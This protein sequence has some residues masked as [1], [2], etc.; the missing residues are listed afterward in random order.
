ML[1]DIFAV[2][3]PYLHIGPDPVTNLVVS[4]I[5]EREVSFSWFTGSAGSFPISAIEM[6]VFPPTGVPFRL[7]L[8]NINATT[9]TDLMPFSGYK[10]SI[11]VVNF[12]GRSE[13]VNIT[14][15]TLSQGMS[16][17]ML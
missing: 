5:G 9:V 1:D 7:I 3:G 6:D 8:S 2:H 17:L 13:V 10:F 11:A 4:S 14:A 15:S 12:A 16:I